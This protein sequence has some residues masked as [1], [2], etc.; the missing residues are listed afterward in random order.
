MN[1]NN[2]FAPPA[3]IVEDIK[4]LSSQRS[5]GFRLS[6]SLLWRVLIVQTAIGMPTVALLSFADL[7]NTATLIKFKPSLIFIV[8]SVGLAASLALTSKGA[9]FLPWGAR[10]NLSSLVWRWLTWLFSG[11]YLALAIANLGVAYSASVETWVVYKAFFPLLAITAL[12]IAAPRAL[13]TE[14]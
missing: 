2:P 4:G 5:S 13:P 10:L 7:A 3:S 8:I 6:V 9:L 14:A 1:D 11:L 12:C